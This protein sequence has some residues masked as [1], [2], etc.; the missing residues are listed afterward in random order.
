[1]T[2]YTYIQS[3]DINNTLD[4]EYNQSYYQSNQSTSK[5]IKSDSKT[6]ESDPKNNRIQPKNNRIQPI[7]LTNEG[8]SVQSTFQ[9]RN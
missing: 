8:R 4:K 9:A 7:R 1:M 2:L 6:M 3:I 5:T